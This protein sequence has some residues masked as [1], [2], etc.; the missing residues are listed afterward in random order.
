MK[1]RRAS[2]GRIAAWRYAAVV[3]IPLRT[4]MAGVERDSLTGLTPPISGW[5]A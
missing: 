2:N 5:V 3:A 4:Y 1:E